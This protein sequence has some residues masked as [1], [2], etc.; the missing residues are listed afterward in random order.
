MARLASILALCIYLAPL[1]SAAQ[2]VPPQKIDCKQFNNFYRVN[3]S[4]FRSEQPSR[5]GIE[6]L[7]SIGIRSLLSVRSKS[8]SSL[9]GGIRFNVYHIPMTTEKIYHEDVVKALAVIKRSPKPLLIHCS[10]GADRTGLIIAAYRIVY[11]GWTKEQAIGEMRNGGYHFD[12]SLENMV[13]Y[14]NGL[15]TDQIR[16]QINEIAQ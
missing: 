15:D 2:E 6:Y 8:D 9:I 10:R 13:R 7:G 11:C 1:H 5:D 4:I 3:D 14:L 12:Q 16:R